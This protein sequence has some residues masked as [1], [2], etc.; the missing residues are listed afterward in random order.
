MCSTF[1][2]RMKF[3]SQ[4]L[5]T[6][7][8]LFFAATSFAEKE[9]SE[10]VPVIAVID[11]GAD[12]SHEAIK[13]NLWTNP[14]EIPG[15]GIDDDH[16]G[17]IDD[18]HGWNF[19]ENNNVLDDEENHGT[20]IAGVIQSNAS[21]NRHQLMILKYFKSS[22]SPQDQVKSMVSA[23]NYAIDNGAD[24]I[25]I[26]AGG[27][28]Y[29]NEEYNLLKKAGDKGI[30]IVAASGNKKSHFRNKDFYPSAYD[31]PNVISV[32]A[33]N[34][35]GEVLPTTNLNITKSSI[36]FDGDEIEGPL[37]N[38]QFGKMTGSSQA[39]AGFTGFLTQYIK[40]ENNAL[41]KAN[42][43]LSNQAKIVALHTN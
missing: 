2:V 33:T 28:T 14:L 12:L 16:N 29:S 20:H 40:D 39:A 6:I 43:I 22:Q 25:N 10:K 23:L 17:Y 3:S 19:P 36:M 8:P 31:L 1:K 30:L 9:A 27:N 42:A 18:V 11:T 7:L 41:L 13:S 37:P 38:N 15:N 34:S 24:I 5:L 26:S 32:S 35:S 4:L 21:K